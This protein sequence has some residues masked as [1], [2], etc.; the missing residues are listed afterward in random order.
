MGG[1]NA[2]GGIV[3]T[4][5]WGWGGEW[6]ETLNTL[7]FDEADGRTTVTLTILYPSKEARDAAIATGMA[8]G[9]SASF[10]RLDALLRRLS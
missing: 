6:P 1:R 10:G 8:D 3:N 4:E 5:T 7:E 2:S 9:A